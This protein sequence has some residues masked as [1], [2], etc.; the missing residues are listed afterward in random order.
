M[1]FLHLDPWICS[2]L[3]LLKCRYP[4]LLTALH[5]PCKNPNSTISW[6]LHPRLHLI[7]P[8]LPFLKERH[9]AAHLSLM[10]PPPPTSESYLPCTAGP[11]WTECAQQCCFSS[12]YQN[13]WSPSWKPGPVIMRLVSAVCR[14][15]H[16]LPPPDQASFSKHPQCCHPYYPDS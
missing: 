6:S 4:I 14:N 3:A 9:P 12:N 5:L 2:K 7:F 11:S 15:S 16:Q 8:F 1:R 10:A 13:L